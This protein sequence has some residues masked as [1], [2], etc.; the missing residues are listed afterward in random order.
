M[1]RETDRIEKFQV[2]G[3]STRELTNGVDAANLQRKSGEIGLGIRALSGQLGA[4]A[5]PIGAF[6]GPFGTTSSAPH[7]HG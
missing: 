5:G 4:F 7:T 6:S 2:S 1:L 3:E